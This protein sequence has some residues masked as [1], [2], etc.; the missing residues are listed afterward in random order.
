[1][2]QKVAALEVDTKNSAKILASVKA[3][4]SLWN[5]TGYFICGS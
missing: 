3:T 2:G 4:T 1:M 5:R